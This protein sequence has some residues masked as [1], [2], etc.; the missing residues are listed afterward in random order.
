MKQ[1]EKMIVGDDLR[2]KYLPNKKVILKPTPRQGTMVNDPEHKL[3][4]M[5]EDAII[6]WMLPLNSKTG[7]LY[8]IFDSVEER[9]FFENELAI[10][11]NHLKKSDNFWHTF[12]VSVTKTPNLMQDGVTFDLSKPMDALK[13]KLLKIQE[14]IAPNWSMRKRR[15]AYRWVIVDEAQEYVDRSSEADMLSE[16]YAHFASIKNSE[17][18]MIEFLK[19]YGSSN[20][21]NKIIPK[22]AKIEFLKGEVADIITENL[23]GYLEV[24]KG[25]NFEIKVMIE[26]AL[27]VGALEVKSN[28][29]ML[30]GGDFVNPLDPS[31]QGTILELKTWMNPQNDNYEKYMTLKARI[32][33]E[34]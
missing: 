3:Y 2:M 26:K 21:I 29:Y 22:E 30:P 27:E 17:S 1:K 5:A 19:I 28:K 4:F 34:K 9:E 31:Y 23:K 33:T 11:L 15:P 32:S 6:E 10:D 25:G 18:K 16:A 7:H 13:V 8:D 24:I 12:K 14:D 20:K